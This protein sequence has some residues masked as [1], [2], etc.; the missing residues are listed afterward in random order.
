VG[1]RYFADQVIN[2]GIEAI[3]HPAMAIDEIQHLVE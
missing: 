1:R 3:G 2:E